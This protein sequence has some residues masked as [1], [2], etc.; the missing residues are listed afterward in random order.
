ME[1][2]LVLKVTTHLLVSLNLEDLTEVLEVGALVVEGLV[3]V[4]VAEVLED[5]ALGVIKK[6]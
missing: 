5:E 3:E 4:L 2:A 1:V 6:Y